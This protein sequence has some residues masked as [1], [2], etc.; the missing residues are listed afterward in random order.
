MKLNQLT[1]A[2]RRTL[3]EAAGVNPDSL[4]HVVKGRRKLSAELASRLEAAAKEIHIQLDRGS[5]CETCRLC[6][7]R[8]RC[9]KEDRDTAGAVAV[10]KS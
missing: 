3:A 9:A 6:P 10:P 2:E 8:K 5:L 4:R 1:W 7:Y